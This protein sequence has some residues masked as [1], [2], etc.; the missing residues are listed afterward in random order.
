MNPRSDVFRIDEDSKP[1]THLNFKNDPDEF[2]FAI[3]TDNAGG[4]RPG[5]FAK[6]AEM[7]NLLQPEFV[8]H[9]GDLIEGYS[10]DEEQL[11]AWW[12][13]IDE[14]LEQ[15]E[16]PFFFVPGNHDIFSDTAIKI[17]RERFGSER[18][19][20]HFVYKNVLFL[21]VDTEDP[22][23]TVAALQR[24]DPELYKKIAA[25]YPAMEEL[26]KKEHQTAEDGKRLLEL[27]EP[28]EDW[29]GEI[30]ISDEQV[31]YFKEVVEANPDVRWT[32]VITHSPPHFTP[33][34]GEK[35]PGNFAKI[36][37]LLADRPYT[38]IS[39]HT[40]TYHYDQR[41]G[42]D[43]I[44]TATSGAM[45]VVRP[46]AMDHVVWITMTDQGPKIVNLLL[47]GMFDKEGP[48]ED[49]DLKEIG[50]YRPRS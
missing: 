17:W 28:V 39:A 14:Y 40:H 32:F 25:N 43:F 34:T 18:A 8:V 21:M 26:Q 45:N 5:V 46:G 12:Q 41:N 11:R 27:A 35:D 13:E 38:V 2:Q 20:Y 36:E 7:A 22:P 19:Y 44:T 9:A 4:A 47:N 37:A 31:A 50:L 49:D 24:D 10:E 6:A 33:T 42:R 23:K 29:L 30:N 15:L 16:M 1:Y 48:P 3:I